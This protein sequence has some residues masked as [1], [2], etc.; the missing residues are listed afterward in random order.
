MTGQRGVLST[1]R[2]VTNGKSRMTDK[3]QPVGDF[4]GLL[5]RLAQV[6]K[7]ELDAEERKYQQQRKRL[8]EKGAG[9]VGKRKR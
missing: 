9:N 3:L 1:L 7:A 5:R 2:P 8:R 4:N 6:P